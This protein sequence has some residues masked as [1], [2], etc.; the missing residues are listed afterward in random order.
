[1]IRGGGPRPCSGG[2]AAVYS[3]ATGGALHQELPPLNPGTP[4]HDISNRSGG[5]HE[6]VDTN[7]V[8]A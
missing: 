6:W 8:Q 7:Q 5:Y 4:L 1:M 3:A 2:D